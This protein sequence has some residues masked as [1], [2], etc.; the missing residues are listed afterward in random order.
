MKKILFIFLF[1]LAALAQVQ[2]GTPN[3]V[4]LVGASALTA[5]VNNILPNGATSTDGTDMSGYGS[6]LVQVISTATAGTFIFEG[7]NFLNTNYVTIPVWNQA[8]ATGTPITAAIT[9]TAS[10]IGYWLPKKFRYIRLRIATTLT[11]GSVQAVSVLTRNDSDPNYF[12]VS[13]ATA[14][15]LNATV[16][17]T[18]LSTNISQINGV[19]PLMGNGVTGTGSPRVTISS[20]NTSNTNPWLVSNAKPEAITDVASAA[21]TT[22]TTTAA[23]TPTRGASYQIA[24]PVTVVSGTSPTND[25][26]IE[27]SLDG[28]NWFRVWDMER[29][30]AT[31]IYYSPVMPYTGQQVRYVQTIGGTTPSFTR[32]VVRM[33][34][35][36]TGASI[37]RRLIDRSISLTTLNSTSPVLNTGGASIV[38]LVINVGAITTT[39]PAIS[40]EGSEEASFTNP[41][42][43]PVSALTAVASST[44]QTTLVGVSA[45]FVRAKVTTAGVGVTAGYIVIKAFN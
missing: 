5:T 36:I 2:N 19:A 25:T 3:D 13:N 18:N 9:A 28:T 7:S 16:T 6:A 30:T 26:G 23:F 22:T 12:Q 24:I 41:Y 8:T 21:I 35:N 33:Q 17:A 34:S 27:E 37:K 32:S 39:A 15:N 38:Q 14:A 20:D 1:P 4:Y 31:G 43:L 29:I 40:L 44:V 11:G 10:T 42:T 45:P